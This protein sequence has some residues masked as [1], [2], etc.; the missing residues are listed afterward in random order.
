LLRL[1]AAANRGGEAEN[2]RNKVR[3]EKE[4]CNVLCFRHGCHAADGIW[5]YDADNTGGWG[6]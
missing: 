5:K 2:R 4:T 3:D 1:I 6:G